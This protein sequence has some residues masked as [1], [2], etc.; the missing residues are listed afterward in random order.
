MTIKK[1]LN[2]KISLKEFIHDR[3][4]ILSANQHHPTPYLESILEQAQEE[5]EAGDFVG[6][7]KSGKDF[8][9][10]LKSL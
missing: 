2:T 5:Y 10:H 4:I 3:E 6:P 7:F 9:T 1:K 8:I